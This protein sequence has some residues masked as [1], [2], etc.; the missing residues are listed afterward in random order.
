MEPSPFDCLG[1]HLGRRHVL[2]GP[3]ST[4]SSQNRCFIEEGGARDHDFNLGVSTDKKSPEPLSSMVLAEI[5]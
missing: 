2:R 5:L 3:G 1:Q 4:G